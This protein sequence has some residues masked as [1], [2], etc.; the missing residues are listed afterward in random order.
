[1]SSAS[2]QLER[3]R[4]RGDLG[5][6]QVG[7]FVCFLSGRARRS[8]PR[9]GSTFWKAGPRSVAVGSAR[10]PCCHSRRAFDGQRLDLL[11]VGPAAAEQLGPVNAIV[12]GAGEME[13]GAMIASWVW[14]SFAGQQAWL[15]RTMFATPFDMAA[16]DVPALPGRPDAPGSAARLQSRYDASRDG[17]APRVPVVPPT[18]FPALCVNV[19]ETVGQ[20]I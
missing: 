5:K 19:R 1:M 4:T 16:S 18:L 20:R 17:R 7:F 14:R 12:L 13:I 2:A 3:R 8:T 10:R 9:T 6:R 15:S 11:G